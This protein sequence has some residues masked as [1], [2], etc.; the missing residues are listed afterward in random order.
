[1][2]NTAEATTQTQK[3]LL[4]E[5]KV[6]AGNPEWDILARTLDILPRTFKNYRL[7][8]DSKNYRNMHKLVRRDVEKY[9]VKLQTKLE[10]AGS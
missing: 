6:L 10:K 1:M 4:N 3:E 7:P 2:K 5:I 8:D 9:K